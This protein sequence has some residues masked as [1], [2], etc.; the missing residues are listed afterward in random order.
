[1]HDERADHGDRGP[2]LARKGAATVSEAEQAHNHEQPGAGLGDDREAKAPVGARHRITKSI[3]LTRS[4]LH[5]RVG[6]VTA[7]NTASRVDQRLVPFGG[8]AFA[9]R[10]STYWA[11]VTS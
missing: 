4:E 5:V 1:V 10:N 2:D 9:F 3:A 6:E 7:P 8:V 11:F